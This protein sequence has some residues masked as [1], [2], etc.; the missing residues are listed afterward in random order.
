M[1]INKANSILREYQT[2]AIIN[3]FYQSGPVSCRRVDFKRKPGQNT[4]KYRL[5][6][7]INGNRTKLVD[8]AKFLMSE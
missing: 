2:M 8:A 4:N 1:H 6:Y 7:F 3:G 5:L